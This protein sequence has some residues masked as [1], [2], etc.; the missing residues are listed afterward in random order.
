[1]IV[2]GVPGASEGFAQVR[3]ANVQS[4]PAGPERE[5]EVVL[6]GSDS[7]TVVPLA[8]LG[9]ALVTTWV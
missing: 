8:L 3:V 5:T 2:A 9:P 6:D 7:L 4:Q 1:V